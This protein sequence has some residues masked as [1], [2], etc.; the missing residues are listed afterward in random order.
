MS[1]NES[2]ES[3]ETMYQTP[4]SSDDAN[5]ELE[6]SRPESELG[7]SPEFS[8]PVTRSGKKRKNP[9]P[10]KS[11]GKKKNKMSTICSPP[12]KPSSSEQTGSPKATARPAA[13]PTAQPR[14]PP[15]LAAL[16][17]S[18]LSNI[19]SSMDGME[20]RLVSLSNIQ[21]SMDG[22]ETRLASK[23][24]KLESTVS[25]NKESIVLLT[26]TVNKNTVDLA[27]L[28]SQMREANDA[29]ED[30]VSHIVRSVLNRDQHEHSA[31]SY[32]ASSLAPRRLSSAQ[33]E[34]FERCRRSLRLWPVHGQ[35]LS[36]G[37]RDFLVEKLGLSAEMVEQDF[38]RLE[39]R[40]VVEP[41]SKIPSEV[42][43]EFPSASI[44]D[45]VKS[46][47]YKLEGQR[48]GMRIEI[49][50]FLK[51]DF[52]VL[53]SMA[54]KMKQNNNDIKRS[55]KFDDHSY[56]LMLDI[57]LPG[58][59]WQRIRPEQAREARRSDP[60]IA[61]GPIEMT[62]GM[63]A[64]AVRSGVASL[65]SSS[66]GGTVS[67]TSITSSFGQPQLAG[68]VPSRMPSRSASASSMDGPPSMAPTSNAT[69]AAASGSNSVP[70]GRRG[71]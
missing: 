20:T 28:E 26:D 14:S 7:A 66:C 23:I 39:T 68:G 2:T 22:M 25:S 24:D 42:T 48:A 36:A 33:I 50:N 61:P 64:G 11:A 65:E 8:G 10:V 38:G 30:K 13:A 43:V 40:R 53:Q 37:A 49:P 67:G 4:G 34:R 31:I 59:Q 16:L 56:G 45:S 21:G 55:V 62:S 3:T 58:Q 44:R 17:K 6:P 32:D 69:P 41:R 29:L 71:T 60:T 19:Q 54:Y 51:S 47:G 9:A 5:E 46:A 63:I 12:S 1:V 35:D 15:D 27:R 52:H 18:G 70:L 57:Q